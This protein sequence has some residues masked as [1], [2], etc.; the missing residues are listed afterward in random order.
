M[1]E[2]VVSCMVM[3]KECEKVREANV[4]VKFSDIVE[5]NNY[6]DTIA[7]YTNMVANSMLPCNEKLSYYE[8]TG[9]DVKF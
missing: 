5:E 7:K 6:E 1:K 4:T 8:L 3:Y 2:I 9:I